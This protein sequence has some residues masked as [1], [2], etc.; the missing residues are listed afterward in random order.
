VI[1]PQCEQEA[2]ERSQGALST[3]CPLPAHMNLLAADES[4]AGSEATPLWILQAWNV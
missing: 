2:P 3:Q 4:A 1:D